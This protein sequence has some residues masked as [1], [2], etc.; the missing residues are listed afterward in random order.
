MLCSNELC[1]S[2][3]LVI[4]FPFYNVYLE[5]EKNLHTSKENNGGMSEQPNRRDV[6]KVSGGALPR[7]QICINKC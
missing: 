6:A 3:G 4:R 5:K 7:G 1:I 2:T